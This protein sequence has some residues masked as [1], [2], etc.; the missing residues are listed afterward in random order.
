MVKSG[1]EQ[2]PTTSFLDILLSKLTSRKF[3]LGLAAVI[4]SIA[5]DQ[6][7]LTAVAAAIYIAVEGAVDFKN[8]Q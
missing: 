2:A 7:V 8:R 4:N 1:G 6:P 5:N 3:L